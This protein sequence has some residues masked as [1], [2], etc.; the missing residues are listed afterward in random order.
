M[1]TKLY[2]STAIAVMAINM[3]GVTSDSCA[4][5][6]TTFDLGRITVVGGGNYGGSFDDPFFQR[7][8]G[9]DDWDHDEGDGGDGDPVED[10]RCISSTHTLGPLTMSQTDS[11]NAR[12]QSFR[13][14]ISTLGTAFGGVVGGFFSGGSMGP[15]LGG[16]SGGLATYLLTAAP[17][18]HCGDVLSTSQTVCLD[19]SVENF[20]EVY[21]VQNP[22]LHTHYACVDDVGVEPPCPGCDPNGGVGFDMYAYESLLHDPAAIEAERAII[23]AHV[24]RQVLEIFQGDLS[25]LDYPIVIELDPYK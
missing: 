13:T 24:Q 11:V 16:L 15:T 17:T 8:D 19:E 12:R 25:K 4:W 10:A 22:V 3:S 5:G 7:W 14:L 23:Q 20:H 2:F 6:Y 9:R 21:S 1:K 18:V